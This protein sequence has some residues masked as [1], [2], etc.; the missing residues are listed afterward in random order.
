[1]RYA[2][3]GK[4]FISK[5]HEDAIDK[6]G[7]R[8]L[9]AS[10]T[11]PNKF[12]SGVHCT[13][14]YEFMTA[15]PGWRDVDTVVIATPND[16]H[17]EMARWSI[18]HGKKVICEKPFSI[19]SASMDFA[20]NDE[21]VFVVMQ[22][23]HHPMMKKLRQM[24]VD[25]FEDVHLYVRVKRGPDYWAGWKGDSSQ[26]GGVLFNIGV[27]YMDA[28]LELFGKDYEIIESSVSDASAY[29]LVRFGAMRNPVRFNVSITDTDEGQDRFLMV[30]GEKYKFS[31]KDNLSYED[32]HVKVYQD[33]LEGKGVHPSDVLPL[34]KFIEELKARSPQE[35]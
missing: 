21:N 20:H 17:V 22:L 27:H 33:F 5:R 9:V 26:S 19:D 30:N 35:V 24:P 16:L 32:L 12:G 11:D 14:H 23:R 7:G 18:R 31:D 10:D 28:L 29:G 3:I 2:L 4:G 25:Q 8:L 34:T 1:M 13:R 15:L 6:T